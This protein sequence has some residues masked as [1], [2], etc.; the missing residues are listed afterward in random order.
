[1]TPA[2]KLVVALEQ[3]EL[4]A[5]FAEPLAAADSAIHAA[6]AAAAAELFP[7]DL[8][9]MT[10]DAVATYTWLSERI[11]FATYAEGLAQLHE[12]ALTSNPSLAAICRS[13]EAL[14]DVAAAAARGAVPTNHLEPHA[15]AGARAVA[16]ARS[17]YMTLIAS[18]IAAITGHELGRPAKALLACDELEHRLAAERARR[19]EHAR[20][21]LVRVE[22][23]RKAAAR[24]VRDKS[25]ERV[26]E[27]ER[28]AADAAQIAGLTA[29]EYR[30]ARAEWFIERLRATGLRELRVGGNLYIVSDVIANAR[31]FSVQQLER[32]EAALAPH[33]VE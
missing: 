20:A 27:A 2:E 5:P 10:M 29:H 4:G 26:R 15:A 31:E 13:H 9:P 3:L 28:K 16:A 6:R 11:P 23:E 21:E 18:Q 22:A 25:A 24:A 1:M 19:E 14:D 7:P 8:G 30:R 12:R 17:R 33:E 32:H